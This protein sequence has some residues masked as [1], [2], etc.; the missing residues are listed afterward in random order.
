MKGNKTFYK[1]SDILKTEPKKWIDG[2]EINSLFG[3]YV[4][5]G[6]AFFESIKIQFTHIFNSSPNIY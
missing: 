2:L 5:Y 3:P 1:K 6:S 4:L